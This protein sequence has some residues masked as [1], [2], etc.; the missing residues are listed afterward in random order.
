[1]SLAY[2]DSKKPRDAAE[3][4]SP[5]GIQPDFTSG[6]DLPGF[7]LGWR[8]MTVDRFAWNN[9]AT[10]ILRL[11]DGAVDWL[12]EAAGKI[13]VN[14]NEF[15]LSKAREEASAWLQSKVQE[16]ITDFLSRHVESP[17]QLINCHLAGVRAAG[18]ERVYWKF[19][20]GARIQEIVFPAATNLDVI[21]CSENR[22]KL[23]WRGVP[24]TVLP[25]IE[26]Q[27]TSQFAP[28][29]PSRFGL[30]M[31]PNFDIFRRLR[32]VCIPTAFLELPPFLAR[33]VG[34]QFQSR[35]G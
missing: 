20:Q 10:D 35:Q 25:E 13:T 28:S 6:S 11:V 15:K 34:P 19:E 27:R 9:N 22:R 18:P 23:A 33:G 32:L 14:R 16:Q 4:P 8:G 26:I 5:V 31:N 2:F 17:Y 30:A 1:V 3:V 24:V 21:W 12:S 29:P 7:Q